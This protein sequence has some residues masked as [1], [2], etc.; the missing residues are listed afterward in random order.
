MRCSEEFPKREP[1]TLVLAGL[2]AKVYSTKFELSNEIRHFFIK[3]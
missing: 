3:S 1:Y 2:Q